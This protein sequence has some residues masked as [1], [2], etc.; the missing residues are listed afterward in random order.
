MVDDWYSA[1]MLSDATDAVLPLD[2]CFGEAGFSHGT[3]ANMQDQVLDLGGCLDSRGAHS[4][5]AG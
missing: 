4:R 2:P 3:A 5:G 1:M